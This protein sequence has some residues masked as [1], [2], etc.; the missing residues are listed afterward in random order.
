MHIIAIILLIR[1]VI[2]YSNRS[3]NGSGPSRVN[4][5]PFA[6][7]LLLFPFIVTTTLIIDN[8]LPKVWLVVIN[9]PSLILC[10]P[11]WFAQISIRCGWVKISYWLGRIAL[12]VHRR[13]SFG[14]ALFYAWLA[15]QHAKPDHVEPLHYWLTQQLSQ[16]KRVLQS[17]AMVMQI[18]L[19]YQRITDIQLMDNLRILKG[20]NKALIP[21]NITRYACRFMLARDLATSNW[22]IINA[23]AQQWHGSAYNPLATWLIKTFRYKRS[24]QKH[25]LKLNL[26]AS[27]IFAGMPAISKY[28][29]AY[30]TAYAAPSLRD[31]SAL[32][33]QNLVLAEWWLRQHA[34]DTDKKL[35]DYWGEYRQSS[36]RNEWLPR[37]QQLGIFNTDESFTRLEKSITD[38]ISYRTGSDSL[39][40]DAIS[41]ERDR[42]FNLLRIKIRAVTSRVSQKKL[43]TGSQEFEEWCAIALLAQQLRTDA[44]SESQVYYILR[45]QCWNWVVE[46]WNNANNKPLG[47]LISSYLSP[48]TFTFSDTEANTFFHGIITNRFK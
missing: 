32:S 31:A 27:Y 42:H 13:D 11:S 46:L 19:K 37:A 2:Y 10:F 14:G 38:V 41:Q 1:I 23:T 24:T 7:F 40:N 25:K 47:F 9:I 39:D 35:N 34:Q 26:Y 29:P 33:H 8:L 22:E 16:R 6:W 20:C 4:N 5:P 18:L 48:M 21:G 45:S 44:I 17:G 28:L 36:L 43:M 15:L 30:Q 12:A 3:V